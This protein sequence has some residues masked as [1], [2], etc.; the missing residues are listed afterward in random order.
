ML[1]ILLNF[2]SDDQKIR[3][4][5]ENSWDDNF[6]ELSEI[7]FSIKD[8]AKR[9]KAIAELSLQDKPFMIAGIEDDKTKIELM[10][11][12]KGLT[13][14]SKAVI[15]RSLEDDNTK[16]K[17]MRTTEGLE[18]GSKAVIIRS[19]EDDNTKIELMRT[20][21]G[22]E[23]GDKAFILASLENDKKKIELMRTTEGLEPEYKA[24]IIASL[25]DNKTK[26]ELMRTTEGL[27]SY[28]KSY[29]INSIKNENIRIKLM[30]ITSGLSSRD[31]SL[32]ICSLQDTNI[33]INALQNV[34][35]FTSE[36]KAELIIRIDDDKK[37][38]ELMQT[39]D[40]LDHKDKAKII[41]SIYSDKKKV[42]LMQIIDELD[43]KDKARIIG[44][45]YSIEIKILMYSANL[46][47]D[48]WNEYRIRY[49]DIDFVNKNMEFFLKNAMT[50][51]EN[52]DLAMETL[53]RMFKKNNEVVKGLDFRLLEQKYL[54]T[55]GEERINL[56]SCYPDIQEQ[57]LKLSDEQL[58]I[59]DK[60]IDA[61]VEQNETDEWT[62]LAKELLEHLGE[63]DSL[64]EGL[65]D[66]ENI[67]K[68]DIADLARIMQGENWC[69]ISSIDEAR[70]YDRIKEEKSKAIMSDDNATLEEKKQAVYQKIFGH[71][72]SY[73]EIMIRKYGE[74]IEN[75]DECEMKDYIRTLKMIDTIDNIDVLQEIFEKCDFAEL[76]KVLAERELKTE[77]GKKF[78]TDLYVPQ[79][80][81]RQDITSNIYEV[82]TDFKIILTSIGAY[83]G[84]TNIDN[85]KEDWNRPAI[86]TQHFCASY[87]RN[88]MIGTAPIHSICYGFLQ[89]KE[90]A[91]MLSG[92]TDI[93]SSMNT[94]NS[95][96][97]SDIQRYYTPDTQ[98]DNTI[99]HNEM[100]FRRIQGGAKVQPDYIVVFRRNGQIENMDEAQRASKQWDGMPIVV[101]DVNKCLESERAKVDTMITQYREN[102]SSELA[103]EIIQKVRNNRQTDD[104]FC[105]DLEIELEEIRIKEKIQETEKSKIHVESKKDAGKKSID[106]EQLEENYEG[107]SAKEREQ[108]VSKIR[109]IYR[110]VKEISREGK[111]DGR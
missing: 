81:D 66:I 109:E 97:H 38:V 63:Y 110:N 53:S 45:F 57:I 99:K 8:K 42:E 24:A 3:K 28:S 93:N 1:K 27:S 91:L 60:C 34:N 11:K 54:D 7:I 76:D 30:Q 73:A 47:S 50:N 17:L 75:I 90:D 33:I 87:I 102:P 59:F 56:I 65:D 26:I 39:I 36:E 22:L 84:E 15:I 49:A 92:P 61:Y 96:A 40:G 107:I 106:E 43:H 83:F 78:F 9:D 58:Y 6:K 74:D 86:S 41:S 35:K 19:L 37:K 111:D 85:Y 72:L 4:I 64:I 108:E 100:D 55:L 5:Q 67:G 105:Q 18:S 80:K 44:D 29:I 68:E 62:T 79:E 52:I 51:L 104:V 71:D 48:I 46:S 101:I 31:K 12:T 23:F 95:T 21:E 2:M 98:I 13:S 77:Y 25:E 82:E 16:I 94:F 88:D 69:E 20:T 70:D 103:R 32:I 89:M 14:G 10:R